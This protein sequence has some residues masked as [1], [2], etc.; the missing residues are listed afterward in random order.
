MQG[1]GA[2]RGRRRGTRRVISGLALAVMMLALALALAAPMG[3]PRAAARPLDGGTLTITIPQPDSNGE[4]A[5]P[6]G[7]NLTVSGTGL[8]D[9]D[10]YALGYASQDNQ[11]AS[12]FPLFQNVTATATGG[13]FT[14]TFAWPKAVNSVGALYYICAQDTN[15]P[16][17]PPVQSDQLFHVLSAAAPLF[18]ISDATTQNAIPGPPFT[19]F[20]GSQI[21]L[22][23]HN[24]V[25]ANVTLLVYLSTRRIASGQDFSAAQLLSTVDSQPVTTTESGDVS[26]T[27]AVPGGVKAGTYF[28]Y[29]VSNDRQGNALP[30]L[31][32]GVQVRV[33]LQPTPTASPSPSPTAKSSPGTS[34]GT[35]GNGGLSTGRILGI[36][37]FGLLSLILFVVGTILL[38]SDGRRPQ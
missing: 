12:G 7:I 37:G 19:I 14:T 23:G 30:S 20:A 9:G 3:T 15:Q 38:A 5:G 16:D 13:T 27:V 29:L 8:Q 35:P 36:I 1:S 28:L 25:P 4:I 6:V 18:T 21:N 32:A 11:C 2:W 17:S 33:R 31:M 24:Y 10:T 34:T 22:L 26:A